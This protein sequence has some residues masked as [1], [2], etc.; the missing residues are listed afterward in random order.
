MT[1]VIV[2]AARSEGRAC[3][4]VC[5]WT[6]LRGEDSLHSPRECIDCGAASQSVGNGHLSEGR[7]TGPGAA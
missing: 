5:R 7:S 1:Y 3:V 2:E 4:D 6:A